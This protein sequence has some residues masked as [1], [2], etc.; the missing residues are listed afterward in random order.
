MQVKKPVSKRN[1]DSSKGKEPEASAKVGATK[2]KANPNSN[3][4]SVS[5][6]NDDDFMD[7]PA[8]GT[9]DDESDDDTSQVTFCSMKCVELV[10]TMCLIFLSVYA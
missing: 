3:K 1:T 2:G 4:K 8:E 5:F 9:D 10:I 7:V 6:K